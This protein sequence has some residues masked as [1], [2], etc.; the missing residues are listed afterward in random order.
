MKKIIVAMLLSAAVSGCE[1]PSVDCDYV[2]TPLVQAEENGEV[3]AATDVVAYAFY[4]DTAQWAVANY[5]DAENGILTSRTGGGTMNYAL[6]AIQDDRSDLTLGRITQKPVIV[7]VCDKAGRIYAW[8]Q[9]PME[10]GIPSIEVK[11]YFRPWKT[12]SPYTEGGWYMVNEFLPE[13]EP[14]PEE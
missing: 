2:V 4:A 7:V 8:R 11:V 12:V 3:A 9:I 1:K 10:P 13:P 5:A 14:D 6:S